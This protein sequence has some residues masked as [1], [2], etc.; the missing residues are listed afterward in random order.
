MTFI[1]HQKKRKI[2][3]KSLNIIALKSMVINKGYY[4]SESLVGEGDIILSEKKDGSSK[5]FA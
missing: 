4:N 1:T 2:K 3:D 5:L